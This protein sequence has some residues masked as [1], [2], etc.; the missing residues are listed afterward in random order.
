MNQ[1]EAVIVRDK[2]WMT[3][4]WLVLLGSVVVVGLIARQVYQQRGLKVVISFQDAHGLEPGDAIVHRGMRIGIVR[5]VSLSDDLNAVRVDAELDTSAQMLATDGA[6]F[7]IVRPELSLTRIQGLETVIGPRYIRLIPADSPG[8]PRA[9]FTGFDEPLDS[10][11]GVGDRDDKARGLELVLI[12]NVRGSLVPGS[13][14]TFRDIPVGQVLSCELA[15]DATGVEVRVLIR[16]EYAPLVRSN[17]R[18]WNAS[19]IGL[20]FGWFAGL[21][22]RADSLESLVVGSIAFVTPN[23]PG[24][25]VGEGHVFD[26]SAEAEDNWHKWNPAI[27]IHPDG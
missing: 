2:S 15:S 10:V 25:R 17:S 14:V 22:V 24:D 21:S 16:S 5:K 6:R 1:P 11:P 9:R 4:A 7:W 23:K 20:D 19:G 8:S 13:P 27:P 26:L 18:F 3:W 12:A